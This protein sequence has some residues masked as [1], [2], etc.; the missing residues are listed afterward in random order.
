MVLAAGYRISIALDSAIK[1]AR[2]ALEMAER[3]V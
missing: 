2:I 3:S 1:S